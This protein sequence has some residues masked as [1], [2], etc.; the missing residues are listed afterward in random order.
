MPSAAV[1][2]RRT[3][4]LRASLPPAHRRSPN[5]GRSASHHTV[6][7]NPRRPGRPEIPPLSPGSRCAI[8]NTAPSPA[9]HGSRDPRR[10]ARASTP[11]AQPSSSSRRRAPDPL[12]SAGDT[13]A[14]YARRPGDADADADADAPTEPAHAA[15]DPTRAAHMLY[16]APPAP[17]RPY[18]PAA[19]TASA[20]TD[21][22]VAY[23]GASRAAGRARLMAAMARLA[24]R[25][26]VSFG[27]DA[28]LARQFN[29]GKVVRF[30]D[31][32]ERARVVALARELREGAQVKRAWRKLKRGDEDFWGEVEERE[33]VPVA[34]G[35]RAGLVDRAVRGVY[36]A[37]DEG[38]GKRLVAN[39]TYREREARGFWGIVGK[40]VGRK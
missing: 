29:A 15:F 39:G 18:N 9:R 36:D 30:R 32:D 16:R 31:D 34:G 19:P 6:P 10:A 37:G 22:L 25:E 4:L 20:L 11:G 12:A 27:F 14:I 40:L 26:D 24:R 23:P 28:D 1:A 13:S 21:A 3:T 8:S 17:P 35:Y 5:R 38:L 7:S 33:W 2:V